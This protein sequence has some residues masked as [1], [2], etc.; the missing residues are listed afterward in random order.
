MDPEDMEED[1]LLAEL[2]DS[3][4]QETIELPDELLQAEV[5]DDGLLISL[6]QQ[7]TLLHDLKSKDY[8]NSKLKESCWTEIGAVMQQSGKVTF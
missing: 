7:Y 8:K 2:Q 3:A 6:V 5:I 1:G 4:A